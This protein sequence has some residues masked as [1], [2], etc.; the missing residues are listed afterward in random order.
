[1]LLTPPE[2][3]V[4]KGRRMTRG[5]V[6]VQVGRLV[7]W[8]VLLF[9]A[10]WALVGEWS[11]SDLAFGAVLALVAAPAGVLVTSSAMARGAGLGATVR[12]APSVALAVVLDFGVVAQ[13]LAAAL[14][15]GRR[16]ATGVFRRRDARQPE[17]RSAGGRSWLTIASTFSPNA[18][19][20]ALDD[21]SGEALL[22]ELRPH[23]FSERPL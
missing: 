12:I 11:S 10:W 2:H 17:A 7:I 22:H 23:R 3:V 5:A 8:W 6:A 20:I 21:T 19:V 4:S 13:V 16:D 9:A 18:Y 15:A 1:M 14:L